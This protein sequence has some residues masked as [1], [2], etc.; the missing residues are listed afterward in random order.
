[1]RIFKE[2]DMKK[3]YSRIPWDEWPE[4]VTDMEAG[5][6]RKRGI[7]HGRFKGIICCCAAQSYQRNNR[8]TKPY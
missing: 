5:V 2:V 6:E 1:M 4:A 8:Y 3:E 7:A